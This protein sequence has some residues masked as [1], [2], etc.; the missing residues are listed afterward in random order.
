MATWEERIATYTKLTYDSLYRITDTCLKTSVNL[1]GQQNKTT[2]VDIISDINKIN[3]KDTLVL[4]YIQGLTGRISGIIRKYR[5]KTVFDMCKITLTIF[6]NPKYQ[7]LEYMKCPV[8]GVSRTNREGDR[9][10]NKGT[11]KI[12][13]L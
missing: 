5:V 10:T 2:L 6:R 12:C 9:S 7:H 13:C 3:V 1:L 11:R 8:R 4:P